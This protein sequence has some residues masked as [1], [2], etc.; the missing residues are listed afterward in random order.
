MTGD[1]DLCRRPERLFVDSEDGTARC[2]RCA[3]RRW[4]REVER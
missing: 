3:Y 2:I 1:C 4:L